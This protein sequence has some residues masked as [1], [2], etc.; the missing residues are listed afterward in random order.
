M[1]TQGDKNL[2]KWF[3]DKMTDTTVSAF[4]DNYLD[5]THNKSQHIR[6]LFKGWD[7][8]IYG[9]DML[10]H[11]QDRQLYEHHKL[12]EKHLKKQI[13]MNS[14]KFIKNNLLLI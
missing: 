2:S 4:G 8:A 5:T 14:T 12:Y 1:A 11:Q 9:H 3:N 13:E 10:E 7:A 6:N